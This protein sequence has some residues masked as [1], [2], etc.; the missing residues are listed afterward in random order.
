M[1]R[2]TTVLMLC[3]AIG[4]VAER[5]NATAPQTPTQSGEKAVAE[6]RASAERGDARAQFELGAAYANGQGVPQD[7]V[8]AMAWYRK[9]AERGHAEAQ[10]SV[11]LMYYHGQG[12]PQDDAQAVVWLRNAS[13]QGHQGAQNI[14]ASMVR[15]GRGVSRAT[16][17]ATPSR[18]AVTPPMT[19]A[20]VIEL[21]KAGL[22]DDVVVNAIGMANG[23]AFDVSPASLLELAKAGV[24]S[25]VIV[26]MQKPSVSAA[27]TDTSSRRLSRADLER[28][29]KT[30]YVMSNST[31]QK[32]FDELLKRLRQWGRWTLVDTKADAD[33][34][35]V[36]ADKVTNYGTLGSLASGTG[37]VLPIYSDQ[38]FL[39]LVDP[40]T[41]ENVATISCE[42][43]LGAGYTAGVLVNRLRDRIEPGKR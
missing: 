25:R 38:R 34:L 3:M 18:P 2:L 26:E 17:G 35:V 14:L 5:A 36:F 24:A 12:V 19:N 6:L 10:F 28:V 31:D 32:V 16:P 29:S 30:A 7:F 27:V 22:S 15:A 43:R 9:A 40:V 8:Q 11:A 1:R 21:C 23:R 33:V 42:R 20:D 37:V 41:N 39:I 4:A 13:D